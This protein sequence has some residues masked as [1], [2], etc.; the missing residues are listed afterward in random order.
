MVYF[1]YENESFFFLQHISLLCLALT[2]IQMN[3]HSLSTQPVTAEAVG[4][5]ETCWVAEEASW[6][7]NPC[8]AEIRP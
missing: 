3:L 6:R 7:L 8:P 5:T 4:H 1:S 2:N